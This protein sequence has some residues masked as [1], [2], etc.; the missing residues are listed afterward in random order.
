MVAR[1]RFS[2]R[3]ALVIAAA[4]VAVA[5]VVWLLLASKAATPTEIDLGDPLPDAPTLPPIEPPSVPSPDA[6]PPPVGKAF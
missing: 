5:V 4:T 1:S 2:V 6:P 3:W